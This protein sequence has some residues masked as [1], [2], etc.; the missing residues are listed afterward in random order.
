V[1]AIRKVA[2]KTNP[3]LILAILMLAAIVVRIG[4][5]A[6]SLDDDRWYWEDTIDYYTA[7]NSI[8]TEGSFGTDP[9]RTD[10]VL[11][12]GN[13]PVYPLFMTPFV[14][15]LGRSFTAIR[16]VQSILIVLAVILLYRIITWLTD[17]WFAL[18]GSAYYLFY[19]FYIYLGGMLYP[20]SIYMPALV[21]YVYW[22]L[23]YV[24]SKQTKY[25]YYSVAW[26]ALL[27]HLKMTAWSLLL[28]SA[29]AFLLSN[30]KLGRD[31]FVKGAIAAALFLLVSV[32]WGLRNYNV[33]G[34]ISLPRNAGA[35][36]GQAEEAEQRSELGRQL[37]K[38]QGPLENA[39]LL[40]SPDLTRV[41]SQ[42]KFTSPKV[43][44]ASLVSV[45]PLL[46][47]TVALL[48]LRREMVIY[49]LYGTLFSYALPYLLIKGQTRY[50]IPIDFVMI[51]FFALVVHALWGR[52]SLGRQRAGAG[53]SR[54]DE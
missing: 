14:L 26:L 43:R 40:F 4:Y 38:R 53:P 24:R 42:N 33:Y 6:V 27:G 19:P 46:I 10:I 17:E 51:I 21:V 5:I 9:E 11:P 18:L 47:A 32:P 12:Y 54:P 20:E 37:T 31:F 3:R 50:R 29:A 30:R 36:P 8:V 44:L 39:Y 1:K 28:V 48:F 2:T 23:S 16:I 45:T 7:A 34:R 52:L 41:D 15:A 25:F 49:L 35:G 22:T 13:E